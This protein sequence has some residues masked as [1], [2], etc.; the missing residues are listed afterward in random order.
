MGVH[1][2]VLAV[3]VVNDLEK[4]QGGLLSD[5]PLPLVE[6]VV[7]LQNYLN[8]NFYEQVDVLLQIAMPVFKNILDQQKQDSLPPF[9]LAHQN[10]VGP[11]HVFDKEGYGDLNLL[12]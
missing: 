10:L 6:I 4:Q 3:E 1:E 5:S 2:A 9:L 8:Q 12:A 7:V 11:L